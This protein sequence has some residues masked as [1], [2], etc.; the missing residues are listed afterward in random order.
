MGEASISFSQKPLQKPGHTNLIQVLTQINEHKNLMAAAKFYQSVI[1]SDH[2]K[3]LHFYKWK[4]IAQPMHLAKVSAPWEER[5]CKVPCLSGTS[6]RLHNSNRTPEYSSVDMIGGP[7]IFWQNGVFTGGI[8]LSWR[9]KNWASSWHEKRRD[10]NEAMIFL[11]SSSLLEAYSLQSSPIV[12]YSV[13]TEFLICS[14]LG[15][16]KRLSSLL[17]SLILI[18]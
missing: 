16:L 5:K 6:I 13:C 3:L 17:L 14:P 8:K 1:P 12:N 2:L 9:T 4:K 10:L 7:L 15:G 18:T 11:F